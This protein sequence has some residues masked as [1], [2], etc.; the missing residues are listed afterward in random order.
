MID[1]YNKNKEVIENNLLYFNHQS[2][3]AKDTLESLNSDISEKNSQLDAL[4]NNLTAI[5]AQ[6][7]QK[8]KLEEEQEKEKQAMIDDLERFKDGLRTRK[9]KIELEHENELKTLRK[10]FDDEKQDLI[11][12]KEEIERTNR[13]LKNV[14]SFDFVKLGLNQVTLDYF[15]GLNARIER[16]EGSV[17]IDEGNQVKLSID[18][19]KE[20]IDVSKTSADNF[21]GA[22][23]RNLDYKEVNEHK[24]LIKGLYDNA[25]NTIDELKT[26]NDKLI[27]FSEF[28]EEDGLT[29]L[30]NNW[31]KNKVKQKKVQSEKDNGLDL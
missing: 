9:E 5:T 28:I 12:E 4:S 15:E 30:Y 10:A 16:L 17:V 13:Q 26:Q 22:F 2:K 6:I 21:K 18:D 24:N 20:L 31:A 8:K 7:E 1:L 27:R 23:K 3:T 29:L 14:N 11:S 19:F 25:R